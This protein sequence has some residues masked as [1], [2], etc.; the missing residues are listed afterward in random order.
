MNRKC[1]PS[2]VV[3]SAKILF[4]LLL[5]QQN[6]NKFITCTNNAALLHAVNSYTSHTTIE[7]AHVQAIHE[8][9]LIQ[10]NFS[11][12]YN[13]YFKNDMP[14]NVATAEPYHKRHRTEPTT[15]PNLYQIT[16][17][18]VSR[19]FMDW[20]TSLLINLETLIS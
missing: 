8:F 7:F 16:E 17:N 3:K 18:Q 5:N 6:L 4:T 15:A 19:S 10:A 11:V 1:V 13:G 12:F 2:T 9:Q 14:T 20:G